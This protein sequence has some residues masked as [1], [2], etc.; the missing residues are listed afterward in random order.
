MAE[1]ISTILGVIV[2]VSACASM[3]IKNIK[4]V[5]LCQI[6]CNGAGM[7]SYVLVGGFSGS[8]IYLIAT[9]QS[10]I[11]YIIR[12]LGKTEPK[13]LQPV[14]VVAYVVCSAFTFY[15]LYDLL[16]MLA[17]VLCAVAI[18]QKKSTYYRIFIFFNGVVWIVYDLCILSY[19]MLVSHAIVCFSAMLGIILL[20]LLKKKDKKV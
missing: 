16:P 4:L 5:M 14:V 11:F 1:T 10:I 8:G 3:L 9:V 12:R 13:W 20:D 2:S 18:S 6:I 7:L 15:S 19:A 17:A